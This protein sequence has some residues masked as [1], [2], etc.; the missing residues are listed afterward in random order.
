MWLEM[1]PYFPDVT[2]EMDLK[3]LINRPDPP[4]NPKFKKREALA[5]RLYTNREALEQSRLGVGH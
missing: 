3:S 2:W 5:S 1:L 4:Q